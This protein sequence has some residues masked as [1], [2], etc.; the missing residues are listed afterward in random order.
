MELNKTI[1][2]KPWIS[3]YDK[4]LVLESAQMSPKHKLKS[5]KTT[6]VLQLTADLRQHAIGEPVTEELLLEQ[7]SLPGGQTTTKEQQPSDEETEDYFHH[8]LLWKSIED[9]HFKV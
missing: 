7:L 9:Q 2:E 5:R 4:L 1:A 8:H 6:T 3:N